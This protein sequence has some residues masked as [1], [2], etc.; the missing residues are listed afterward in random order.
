M[1]TET[2]GACLADNLSL[3]FCRHW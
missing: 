1:Q 2:N 3:V